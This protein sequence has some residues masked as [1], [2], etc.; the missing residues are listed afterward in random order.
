MVR[1]CARV[2]VCIYVI[3]KKGKKRSMALVLAEFELFQGGREAKSLWS[4]Q[5]REGWKIGGREGNTH[6]HMGT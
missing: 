3:G 4:A 1:M 2:Y 6:N 5:E